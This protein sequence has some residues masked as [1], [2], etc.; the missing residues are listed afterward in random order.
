MQASVRRRQLHRVD[1]S[2]AY[3]LVLLLPEKEKTNFFLSCLPLS[4]VQIEVMTEILKKKQQAQTSGYLQ[5]EFYSSS[6]ASICL[7][8]SQKQP[9]LLRTNLWG[10]TLCVN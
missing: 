8:F 4:L 2:C 7:L 3:H 10:I 6:L 9:L 1:A 5:A